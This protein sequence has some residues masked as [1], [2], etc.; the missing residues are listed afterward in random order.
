MRACLSE[1]AGD[2]SHKS[3]AGD[4][5]GIPLVFLTSEMMMAHFRRGSA[6]GRCRMQSDATEDTQ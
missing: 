2:E 3:L 5:I 4:V 1:L 6:A